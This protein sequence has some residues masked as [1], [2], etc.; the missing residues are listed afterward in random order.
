MEMLTAQT[1]WVYREHQMKFNAPWQAYRKAPL[2][3][4][5]KYSWASIPMVA[6][7]R[8]TIRWQNTSRD[9]GQC[10]HNHTSKCKIALTAYNR[11]WPINEDSVGIWLDKLSAC[12][13]ECTA[14]GEATQVEQKEG[15][16][17][18]DSRVSPSSFFCRNF[19]CWW[20]RHLSYYHIIKEA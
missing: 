4:F 12:A 9:L 17:T 8:A 3:P 19:S 10:W 18:H 14:G 15:A 1:Y 6:D 20:V 5:S 2:N 11:F 13:A 16:R 7:P